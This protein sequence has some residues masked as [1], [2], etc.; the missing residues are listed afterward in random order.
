[1][2][3]LMVILIWG[4]FLLTAAYADRNFALKAVAHANGALMASPPLPLIANKKGLNKFSVRFANFSAKGETTG[5][6]ASRIDYTGQGLAFLYSKIINPNW[7]FYILGMGNSLS[8]EF[9]SSFNSPTGLL[10]TEAKD[11]K[12]S[13]IQVSSGLTYN[14]ISGGF[15]PIQILGPANIC[16]G[17]KPPEIKL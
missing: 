9:A 4:S 11:V 10:T 2:N 12:G 1:M 13:L 6:L 5:S 7:G 3:K 16:I 8:G 14:L 15:L 17:K